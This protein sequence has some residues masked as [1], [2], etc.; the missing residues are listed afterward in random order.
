[1]SANHHCGTCGSCGGDIPC[2]GLYL[3]RWRKSGECPRA[4]NADGTCGALLFAAPRKRPL[5][6]ERAEEACDV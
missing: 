5:S 6:G 4:V 3:R 2:G 1:M